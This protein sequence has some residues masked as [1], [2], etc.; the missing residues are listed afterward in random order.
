MT[1]RDLFVGALQDLGLSE[2]EAENELDD[3]G[4]D[5]F[6]NKP[7]AAL[8][9]C[10]FETTGFAQLGQPECYEKQEFEKKYLRKRIY[11]LLGPLPQGTALRWNKNRHDFGV[12]YDMVYHYNPD[13]RAHMKYFSKLDGLDMEKIEN[14][15]QSNWDAMKAGQ[16]CSFL[17]NLE[18]D[19]KIFDLL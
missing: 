18:E 9:T 1:E 6:A 4:F 19:N 5:M 7:N 16:S 12:Y 8:E 15:V 2:D 14:G 17:D 13:D 11:D 3:M 10:H